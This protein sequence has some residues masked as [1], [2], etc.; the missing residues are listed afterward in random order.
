[1]RMLTAES[2]SPDYVR[3]NCNILQGKHL[4]SISS[5]FPIKLQDCYIFIVVLTV[6][7]IALSVGLPRKPENDNCGPCNASC[8]RG[9]IG[10][11]SKCFYFSEDMRNWTSSQTSCKAQGAQ[12]AQFDSLE[13]LFTFL[14]D[15]PLKTVE[16]ALTSA[17]ETGLV[18]EAN[19]F[20]FLKT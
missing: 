10:F 11:G 7:V 8:P 1:M 15:Q 3:G 9:W 16:L 13:L 2:T 12:L 20:I 19:V 4:R 18:L 14:G 5:R 17:Q 6:I